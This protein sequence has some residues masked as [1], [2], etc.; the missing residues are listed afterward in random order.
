MPAHH[1][2]WPCWEEGE[3]FGK[4]KEISGPETQ[5][6]IKDKIQKNERNAGN[7]GVLDVVGSQKMAEDGVEGGMLKPVTVAG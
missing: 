5:M 6:H 2:C 4:K 7:S 3:R 1:P